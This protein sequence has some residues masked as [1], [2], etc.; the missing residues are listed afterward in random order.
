MNKTLAKISAVAVTLASLG[1][2]IPAVAAT[3]N[4]DTTGAYI[5]NFNYLGTDYAH[6]MSLT[7]SGAG[8]LTGGGGSPVGANVYTWT[9]ATGTVSGN[10]IVFT[11]NYTA[12]AD[13]V[14]PLTTMHATG[15]IATNGTISG[16]WADNYQGGARSGVFAT[17]TG[18]AIALG[19]LA[20]EDF[21]VVNYDTGL[22]QLKG[23]SAGFGLTDATFADVQ[24]IVVK[25]YAGATLLQTNTATSTFGTLITGTQI[26]SPFDVSGN[27]AYVTDGYWSNVREAEFGQSVPATRVVAKVT[28]ANGKIVTAENTNLSG[29]PTT[30]YPVVVDT[31]PNA[32]SFVDQTGVA[33]STLVTSNEITVSGTNASSTI[34]VVGGEYSVNG[35]SYTMASSTVVSGDT[36]RVRHTSAATASTSTNTVL[37]IGGVS[38]TVT[39]TTVG[40]VTPPP[41]VE[42]DDKNQCK[43]GGWATFTN[44]SFKNQG[45][46][47]SA[48]AKGQHND[49]D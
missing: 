41:P 28:L 43:K 16:T 2:A 29:D 11:A 32:F 33:T 34:S 3:P 23:Y 39:S 42:G 30:I 36:V 1:T 46:C 40:V 10:N 4:W 15:T 7:Q 6:D 12:P 20:A 49:Q 27:F 5:V 18:T 44:P 37:T 22:G 47:V 24:S 48:F 31:T 13:A 21:G 8:A 38:D 26:S 35:G 19:T 17:A 14:T 25:L 45:Q 9:I